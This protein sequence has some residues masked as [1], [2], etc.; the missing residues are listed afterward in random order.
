MPYCAR[1]RRPAPATLAG[2]ATFDTAWDSSACRM[3]AGA[4]GSWLWRRCWSNSA[5]AAATIGVAME[6]PLSRSNKFTLG[7]SGSSVPSGRRGAGTVDIMFT[8]GPA[9]SGLLSPNAVGPRLEKFAGRNVLL[10]SAPTVMAPRACRDSRARYQRRCWRRCAAGLQP[11]CSHCRR[12]PLRWRPVK[13]HCPRPCKA[14]TG[15]PGTTSR[16]RGQTTRA[17][18]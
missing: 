10:V 16:A 1:S 18:D 17:S 5:N 7:G 15:R 12:Q 2:K 11:G 8:P 4:T 14:G 13:R 3:A 9:M 6:V